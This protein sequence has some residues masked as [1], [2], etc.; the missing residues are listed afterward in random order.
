MRSFS[1]SKHSSK[2]E[3]RPNVPLDADIAKTV[4]SAYDSYLTS[5]Q[6][7]KKLRSRFLKALWDA[8]GATQQE[9]ADLIGLSRQRISQFIAE[10]QKEAKKEEGTDT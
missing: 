1:G 4:R 3:Q 7:T 6:V 8:P 10:A 5:R 9:L 2:I